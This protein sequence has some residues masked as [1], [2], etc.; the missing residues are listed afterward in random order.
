MLR[1]V[2]SKRSIERLYRLFG[3]ALLLIVGQPLSCAAE[4]N[5]TTGERLAAIEK[6]RLLHSDEDGQRDMLEIEGYL[7]DSCTSLGALTYRIKDRVINIRLTTQRPAG[8]MCAMVIRSFRQTLPLSKLA[9]SFGD[10]RLEVNSLQAMLRVSAT[11]I[12][13]VDTTNGIP[14]P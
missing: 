9:L 6:I 8:R 2:L 11:G 4:R 3:I 5:P 10:Y 14:T 7:A 12:E 13:L 1:W